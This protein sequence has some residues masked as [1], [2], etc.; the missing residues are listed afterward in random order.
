MRDTDPPR[1]RP[2]ADAARAL[3][4]DALRAGRSVMDVAFDRIYPERIR[5]H[6]PRFWTPVVVARRVAR[7]FEEHGARRVLDIG[8]GCGKFAIIGALTTELDFTGIEHRQGLATTGQQVIEAFGIPRARILHG[9]LD[10]VDFSAYD[11]FYLFNPFEE[12]TF[13]PSRWVDRSVPLSEEGSRQD[14]ARVEEA[15][16]RAPTG[17]CVVTYHGFGGVMP[18]EYRHL[19]EETRGTAFLR[20]W[21]KG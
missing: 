18:T 6:S 14:I 13:Q 16:A 2:R 3:M 4:L 1:G 21:V 15:L 19:A 20:L 8:A 7:I 5:K 17:T 9:T 11:A 12:A 10:T